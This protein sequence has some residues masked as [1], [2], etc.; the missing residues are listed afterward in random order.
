M[1]YQEQADAWFVEDL[2]EFTEGV[3]LYQRIK[4][5]KE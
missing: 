1:S 3:S 2:S 5:R 4:Q